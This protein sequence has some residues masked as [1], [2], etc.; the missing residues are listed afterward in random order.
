MPLKGTPIS[1]VD[2]SR[3]DSLVSN[4]VSEGKKLEYKRD[5]PSSSTGDKKEYLKEVT[6]F[7]NSEG[8]VLIYG[9]GE[10]NGI[11]NSVSPI[12]KN[13]ADTEVG[14]L[15]NLIQDGVEPRPVGYRIETV[16]VQGGVV[17]LIDIP[18]SWTG[19]HMVTIKGEDRFYIRDSEGK[20]RMD[21]TEMKRVVMRSESASE[22]INQFKNKRLGLI[23]S[24]SLDKRLIAGTYLVVHIASIELFTGGMSNE[25]PPRIIHERLDQPSTEL[26]PFNVHGW[27]YSYNIDGYITYASVRNS[28]KVAGYVQF[29]REGA[30]ESVSVI[31]SNDQVNLEPLEREL[32]SKLRDNYIPALES[33]GVNCPL[34]IMISIVGMEGMKFKS[35]QNSRRFIHDIHVIKRDIIETPKSILERYDDPVDKCLKPSIDALWNAAGYPESQSYNDD[36]RRERQI[37]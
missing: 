29:F 8:G 32:I 33:I 23:R 20:H 15:D 11:A 7:S 22:K 19:P 16:D 12:P 30:L 26:I 6:A 21:T 28:S 13:D 34:V 37:H 25:F 31:G 14:R 27:D 1:D 5:L 17:I 4:S 2:E 9:I 35:L 10:N 36:D 3:I 24:N 18:R